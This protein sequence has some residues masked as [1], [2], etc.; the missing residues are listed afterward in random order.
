MSVVHRCVGAGVNGVYGSTVCAATVAGVAVP[1]VVVLAAIIG[2]SGSKDYLWERGKG[3]I[4]VLRVSGKLKP[5]SIHQLI[6]HVNA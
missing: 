4:R 1:V 3:R 2:V 5:E 6:C